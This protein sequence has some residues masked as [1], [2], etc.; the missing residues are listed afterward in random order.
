MGVKSKS[1][2]LTTPWFMPMGD[3]CL[4]CVPT[5]AGCCCQEAP[6]L[7]WPQFPHLFNGSKT[8]HGSRSYNICGGLG[9]AED[10]TQGKVATETRLMEI[11]LQA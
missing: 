7:A 10:F 6:D 4:V 11:V 5:P 9:S 8:C 3:E 1:S 2:D